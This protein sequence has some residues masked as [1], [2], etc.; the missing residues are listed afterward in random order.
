MSKATRFSFV[1]AILVAFTIN[2]SFAI[3]ALVTLYKVWGGWLL[4]TYIFCAFLPWI[5]MGL[6]PKAPAKEA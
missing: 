3:Y 6:R 1:L 2:I 4:L 5:L